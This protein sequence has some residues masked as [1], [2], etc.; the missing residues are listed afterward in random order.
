[1]FR[2][3]LLA[4]FF[5]LLPS[6]VTFWILRAIFNSLVDIFRGPASWLASVLHLPVPPFWGLAL[7]S[8]VT[9]V[10]LLTLTGALV[11]NFVGRQL[12]QW[13]DEL[14]MHVPLVKGIYGATKQL[15]SAIQSGQGGSFKEVVMVEWPRPGAYTL[16]FIAHRDCRWAGFEDG[17]D[18][19]AVYVPTAPNPTSGYVIMVE[20]SKIRP[21]DITPEQALTWAVSGGVVTPSPGKLP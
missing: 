17:E 5:T 8:A 4:G 15:M 19:V 20:A 18:M 10:C 12:L 2:K 7:I 16:G 21:M 13:L 6:V 14:V 1:M 11:G 9:T 3:Y